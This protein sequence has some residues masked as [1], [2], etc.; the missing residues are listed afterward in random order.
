MTETLQ[1]FGSQSSS[2]HTHVNMKKCFLPDKRI[3][4]VIEVVLLYVR[5]VV[6]MHSA[7][8][9]RA[10]PLTRTQKPPEFLKSLKT[11]GNKCVRPDKTWKIYDRTAKSPFT[12][13]PK[14]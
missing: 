3:Y 9:L 11:C 13:H 1:L 5:V 7:I 14:N 4:E 10:E 8:G 2:A 6:E 12:H